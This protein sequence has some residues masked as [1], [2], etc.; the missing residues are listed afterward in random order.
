MNAKIFAKMFVQKLV[1][2]IYKNRT[3]KKLQE[4]D[5]DLINQ[6]KK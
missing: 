2:C 5:E 4:N 6:K 1:S 3:K